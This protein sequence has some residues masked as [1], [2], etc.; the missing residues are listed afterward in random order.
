MSATEI[1]PVE[2]IQSR[3]VV[4]RGQRVLIDR[5]LAELYGVPTKR[6]NQQVKRNGPRVSRGLHVS[7]HA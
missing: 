7:A 3:I 2:I 5:D 4:L 6:F 1:V